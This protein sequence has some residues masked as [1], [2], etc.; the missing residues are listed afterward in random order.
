MCTINVFPILY[1]FYFR[2]ALHIASFGFYKIW[3]YQSCFRAIQSKVTNSH[4]HITE[5][6][7][8]LSL[9]LSLCLS[10]LVNICRRRWCFTSWWVQSPLAA[11]AT[12]NN[13]QQ[14]PSLHTRPWLRSH[15]PWVAKDQKRQGY[16]SIILLP[17]NNSASAVC[18]PGPPV[19]RP[20]TCL[21]SFLPFPIRVPSPFV[22]FSCGEPKSRSQA[23][24]VFI[25]WWSV[26]PSCRN[27]MSRV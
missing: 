7:F 15:F 21:F 20:S 26:S 13:L 2:R 8:T 1:F 12:A 24:S 11:N 4:F 25:C 22:G 19:I 3:V 6:S 9:H 27:E 23:D 5:C 10:S 14:W 16:K 18:L 17:Q